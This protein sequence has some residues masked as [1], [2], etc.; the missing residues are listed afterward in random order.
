MTIFS[1]SIGNVR[2][3]SVRVTLRPIEADPSEEENQ[4]RTEMVGNASKKLRIP[5]PSE[6]DSDDKNQ[7]L[8]ESVGNITP[9]S[10]RLP[11]PVQMREDKKQTT[12][13]SESF[14]NLTRSGPIMPRPIKAESADDEDRTRSA[15]AGNV[16]VDVTPRTTQSTTDEIGQPEIRSQELAT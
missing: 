13:S 2:R 10:V 5:R 3:R 7:P 9:P 11:R 8:S 15:S 14:V 12:R 1:Q 6:M 4:A 16:R